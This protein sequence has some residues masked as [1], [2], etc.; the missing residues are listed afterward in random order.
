MN[1][2]IS[3]LNND[4]ITEMKVNNKI[5]KKEYA[6]VKTNEKIMKKN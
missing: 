3:D 2:K 6:A 4:S 1:V 5:M